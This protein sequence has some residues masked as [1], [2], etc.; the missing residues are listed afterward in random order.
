MKITVVTATWN[1]AAT[2]GD[3]LAS[4]VGQ[5][6]GD[7][8]HVVVDGGSTDG[9]VDVVRGYER[10]YRERGME[11]RWVS[12]RDRGIYDAMNKGIAM[13]TG[14]VVGIL[15]SDDFFCT[16]DVLEVVAGALQRGEGLD[17]VYGDVHYVDP[18]DLSRVVRHYSSKGFRRWKMRL[19]YMPAHPT[20]YCR[21]SV[22]E[23]FG[24][25]NIGLKVAADFE[26][27]LRLIFVNGVRMEY[28]ERD[29]VTMRTGGASNSGWQS[30]KQAMRDH[31]EAYRINGVWSC[32]PLELTRYFCK[33][34]GLVWQ[35][36]RNRIGAG[37]GLT[38]FSRSGEEVCN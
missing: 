6:W 3:T 24:C 4:V 14:D 26:H 27:L 31:M 36:I 23:R 12:E 13:A 5:T 28:I 30:Y 15:N 8:E 32:L 11:L 37:D 17:A 34:T 18:K 7:V 1:S 35:K 33:G 29:F 19:G 9:T 22:Y 16:P 21:R 2:V 10:K 25:F 20:F 38:V